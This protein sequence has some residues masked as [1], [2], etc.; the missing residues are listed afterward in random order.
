MVEVKPLEVNVSVLVPAWVNER[1]ENVA[2]PLTALTGDVPVR[3]PTAAL[4]LIAADEL[5]GFR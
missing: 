2:T 3:L 1:P 4:T 5:T